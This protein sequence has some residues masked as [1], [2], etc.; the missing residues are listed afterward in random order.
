MLE[1]LSGRRRRSHAKNLDA[2]SLMVGATGGAVAASAYTAL[3][4]PPRRARMRDGFASTIGHLIGLMGKARRD[5]RNR[6][7][8][9]GAQASSW[10]RPAFTPDEKLA[11]RIRARLGRFTSHAHAI[12]VSA[13]DGHVVLTGAILRPELNGLI[14]AVRRVRGVQDIESRLEPHDR[15]EDIAALQ[16]T[17]RL[18]HVPELL[19]E[20]WTPSLRVGV[21]AL[22]VVALASGTA[23]VGTVRGIGLTSLGALLL[24][25]AVFDKPMTS[26]LGIGENRRPIEIEKTITIRAPID[27]VFSYLA[28]IDHLPTIMDHLEEVRSTDD[29]HSHWKVRGPLGALIEWDAELTSFVTNER[30]AWRSM[31]GAVVE[32]AGVIR[33]EPALDGLATRLDVRLSY[34]PVAGYIGHAV[35]ALLGA[36]P[37]KLLDEDILRLKSLLEEGKTTAHGHEVRRTRSVTG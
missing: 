35:A 15:A 37:K 11:A 1:H 20:H 5:A 26:I 17:H 12:N 25:R 31:D 4:K 7:R 28:D 2:M 18:A 9:M 27:E 8:G 21:G 23:R 34:N 24:A 32:S 36:A 19:Q 16:G 22:A 3:T 14:H 33:F 29:K 30:I 6:A 10:V 13:K